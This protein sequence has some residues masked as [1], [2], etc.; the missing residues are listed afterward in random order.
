[1]S[2]KLIWIEQKRFEGWGCSECAW[3]FNPLQDLP[4]GTLESLMRQFE[5]QRDQEFALHTC[6]GH[7]KPTRTRP[8]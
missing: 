2:R 4:A 3:V 5:L 8:E 6:A 1:M 7:P